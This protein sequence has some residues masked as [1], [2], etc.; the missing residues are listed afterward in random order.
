[1][2]FDLLPFPVWSEMEIGH[3]NVFNCEKLEPVP[4]TLA[5]RIWP[6][7]KRLCHRIVSF[8]K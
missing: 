6:I 1:M 2:R 4:F 5:F 7:E 8:L 3:F